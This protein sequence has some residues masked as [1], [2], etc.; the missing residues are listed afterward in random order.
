M[1]VDYRQ[2][3]FTDHKSL[4]YIFSQPDL[5]LRQRRWLELIMDY[6]LNVQYYLGKA[7]VVVDVLSR[8]SYCHYM[9]TLN[10]RPELAQ[11]VHQ[12]KLPIVPHGT[13]NAL[14]IRPTLEDQIKEAQDKDEEIQHLKELSGKKNSQDSRLMSK[15]SYGTKT[16]YACH[17]K[18]H[19]ED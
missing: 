14:H 4:K 7:N 18:R 6:D 3:I 12:L 16:G 10:R 19:S 9:T 8:K 11:E 5:S 13:L 17:K 1:N 2:Q 15:E